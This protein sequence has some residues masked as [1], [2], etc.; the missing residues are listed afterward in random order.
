MGDTIKFEVVARD[1]F[2]SLPEP[3][4][5]AIPDKYDDVL[6]AIEKISDKQVICVFADNE[7]D[8]RGK[9][10]TIGRKAR[11]RGFMVEFRND[12]LA[13]YVRKSNEPVPPPK[14]KK[15]AKSNENSNAKQLAV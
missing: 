10:I 1:K 13:L 3:N 9:R 15:K 8:L 4:K 6:T 14:E 7:Q 11:R 5:K 2:E 12:G